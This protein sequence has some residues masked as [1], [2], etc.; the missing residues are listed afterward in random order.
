MKTVAPIVENHAAQEVTTWCTC[1]RIQLQDGRELGFTSSDRPLA[2]E[3]ITYLPLL[4]A[5]QVVTSTQLEVNNL[6]LQTAFVQAGITSKDV[7]GRRFDLAEILVFWVDWTNPP[8]S[9]SLTPPEH[10]E[11]FSGL[12]GQT[13]FTEQ[14]FTLTAQGLL[15]YLEQT[16]GE[17]ITPLCRW[18]LG[19]ENCGVDLLPHTDELT[20]T[21]VDVN[22]PQLL[23]ST[24]SVRQDGFYGVVEFLDGENAG[25]QLRVVAFA[26]GVVTLLEDAPGTIAVGDRLRGIRRCPKTIDA[27]VEFFNNA[28]RFGG[29]PDVPDPKDVFVDGAE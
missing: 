5:S 14:G 6:E 20:V 18:E 9:L 8:S 3:G 27:C 13:R 16:I 12:A 1:W 2:I 21:G 10:L 23:F 4:N 26:A 22:Y 15:A 11:V 7:L 19:D 28:L 17:V 25:Q 29:E 24:D